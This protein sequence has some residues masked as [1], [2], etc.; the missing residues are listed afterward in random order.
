MKI[1]EICLTAVKLGYMLQG[2]KNRQV[3]A[4]YAH[5][6]QLPVQETCETILIVSRQLM[7]ACAHG[8][9]INPVGTI[10]RKV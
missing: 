6:E 7:T 4:W 1:E 2:L 9:D 8:Y 10:Q 5:V 3:K